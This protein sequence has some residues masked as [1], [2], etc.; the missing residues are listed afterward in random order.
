MFEMAFPGS[1]TSPAGAYA[2]KLAVDLRSEFA[3]TGGFGQP[4]IYVS[5]AHG[6]ED[7]KYTFGASKLP[8]LVKLKNLWDPK[9]VFSHDKPIPQKWP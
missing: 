9:D 2:N 7:P 4:E 3:A 8:R 6:D 5:Y 1:A